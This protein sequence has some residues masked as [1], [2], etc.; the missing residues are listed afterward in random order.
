MCYFDVDEPCEVYERSHP[1]SRV[2][3]SC[4]VCCAVIAK[5]ETYERHSMVHDGSATSEFACA[6]CAMTIGAFR[7]HPHHHGSPSPS[8]F[9]EALRECFHGAVRGDP[10]VQLWRDLYAGILRRGLGRAFVAAR[11][12]HNRARRERLAGSRG[13]EASP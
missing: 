5:G 10:E 7:A 3:R 11:I 9:A 2:E 4:D 13:T 1:R 12:K 6:S 8:W